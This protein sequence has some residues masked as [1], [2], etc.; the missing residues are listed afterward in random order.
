MAYRKIICAA[1]NGTGK[2]RLPEVLERTIRIFKPKKRLTAH[3]AHELLAE[4]HLTVAA[5]NNRLEDLRKLGLLARKREGKS[6]FYF[7]S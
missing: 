6:F 2:Q 1:C 4:Y 5:I 3:E 7:L